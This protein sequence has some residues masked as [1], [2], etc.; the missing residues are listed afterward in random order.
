MNAYSTF[1]LQDRKLSP[2]FLTYWTTFI[3]QQAS[4][5]VAGCGWILALLRINIICPLERPQP[6]REPCM[7]P[8]EEKGSL[9]HPAGRQAMCPRAPASLWHPPPVPQGSQRSGWG[10]QGAPTLTQRPRTGR[11]RSHPKRLPVLNFWKMLSE[12]F[13]STR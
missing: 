11:A 3:T 8:Q 4:E 9:C 13:C 2:Y 6:S 5:P 10:A 1:K 12:E 7:W